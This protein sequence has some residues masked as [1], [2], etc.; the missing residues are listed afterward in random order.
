[1]IAS[2]MLEPLNSPLNKQWRQ[3]SKVDEALNTIL[4]VA[5][6]DAALAVIVEE[7]FGSWLLSISYD[8]YC[9][10]MNITHTLT[11]VAIILA[12]IERSLML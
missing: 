6:Q 8:T 7:L 9:V 12:G 10:P 1:M 3:K 5:T 11:E 2:P 4:T